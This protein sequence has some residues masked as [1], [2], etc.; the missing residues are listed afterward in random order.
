MSNYTLE[1][2]GNRHSYRRLMRR[3]PDNSGNPKYAKRG[4]HSQRFAKLPP[5]E[6]SYKHKPK[7]KIK[8]ADERYITVKQL[9]GLLNPSR[10]IEAAN[11]LNAGYTILVG[12]MQTVRKV[13]S[14]AVTRYLLKG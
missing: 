7:E 9:A 3:N 2:I 8:P 12:D 10:Q 4:K 6:N 5:L 14:G 11:L 13:K 1:E